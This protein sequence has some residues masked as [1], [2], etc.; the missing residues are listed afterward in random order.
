MEELL[1]L[2]RDIDPDLEIKGRKDTISWGKSVPKGTPIKIIIDRDKSGRVKVF[3]ECHGARGE[4]EI[5]SPGCGGI[6][7]R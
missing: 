5:V 2:L 4:F 7:M 6:S 3:A 1:E